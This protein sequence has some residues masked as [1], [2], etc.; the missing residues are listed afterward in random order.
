V[1]NLLL[2]G[3]PSIYY[4]QELGMFGAGGFNKFGNTDAN[5]IPRREAFEWY[6]ADTGKGMALWYKGSGPW[7]DSTN[8][9]PFDGVSLEEERRDPRSLWNWY[10]QLLAFRQRNP[11]LQ[12]GNYV[13]LHND[14]A[15]VFSW[16]RLAANGDLARIVVNLSP[17]HQRAVIDGVSR[18]GI[19]LVFG[20]ATVQ[21]N[22]D[23]ITIE[24]PPYGMGVWIIKYR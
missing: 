16:G 20:N 13:M 21:N 23:Q 19:R 17:V 12:T 3:I 22:K 18:P 8:L 2:G 9:K 7:W 1:L 10:R 6:A 5:D 15:N 11:V 4:G 24:L 14:N